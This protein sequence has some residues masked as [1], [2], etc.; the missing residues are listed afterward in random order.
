MMSAAGSPLVAGV[1]ASEQNTMFRKVKVMRPFM[2]DRK[3]TKVGDIIDMPAHS[4]LEVVASGKAE[5][6]KVE[7]VEAKAETV[8]PVAPKGRGS[9]KD[10][11]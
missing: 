3:A 7:P 10:A 9:K 4:A 11:W 6:V 8:D 1:I 5:L 2:L